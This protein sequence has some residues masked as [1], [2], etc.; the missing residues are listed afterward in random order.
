MGNPKPVLKENLELV[1][2]PAWNG[3][4]D[5]GLQGSIHNSQDAGGF[6]G[7]RL[8]AVLVATSNALSY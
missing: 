4:R 3:A 1:D 7:L 2:H 6:T 5:W 8:L